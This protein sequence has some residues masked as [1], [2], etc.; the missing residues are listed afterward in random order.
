[1]ARRV[2]RADTYIIVYGDPV[3]GY[4]FIGPFDTREDG[5]VHAVDYGLANWTVAALDQP[6][7]T[8]D[9]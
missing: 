9:C 1:M 6:E 8:E 5:M 7:E 2:E 3:G 4:A